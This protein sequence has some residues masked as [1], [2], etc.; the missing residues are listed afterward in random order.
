MALPRR[1]VPLRK[2]TRF[3]R[4]LVALA[5]LLMTALATGSYL[6]VAS[7]GNGLNLLELISVPFFAVL[8]GWISFSFWLA[9]L[10]FLFAF[11]EH[12]QYHVRKRDLKPVDPAAA[13]KRT[14]VLMP[15]YNES[16]RRVF[17]GVK[18]M[19]SELRHREGADRF[20]FYILSDTTDPEVWLEEEAAWSELVESLGAGDSLFYRHRAKNLARKAG[21]I[22]DFVER[23]GSR[24]DYMIVLDADSLLAASTMQAM[25]QRMDENDQLGILQIPP[26]PIGRVSFF[27]RL[28]QFAA[29]VYGPSFVKGF[30][31][32]AGDEGNYW[33]HNAI[34]RVEAFRRHCDLPVLPGEP[35]LGGE[36]LSHDFVEAALMVRA[37]WKVQ[38]ATDL[39][40][41]YEECPTTL[42]DYAQ[43]DQRW[44]QGNLQHAKLLVNEEFRTLSQLHFSCGVMSYLASPLWV[45]FTI[46][47]IAGTI[48]DMRGETATNP[49]DNLPG[50]IIIF[51][52]AMLLL[53]LPKLWGV[54]LVSQ[55]RMR[56]A[57]H[58]GYLALWASA[59]LETVC[60]VLLSPIMAVFHT[61]YVIAVLT[62][63]NVRWSAQQR[64]ERSVSWGEATRQFSGLTI[65]GLLVTALLAIFVPSLLAWFSPLLVGVVLS[66]P[67]AVVLGS[68]RIGL[69]LRRRGL[70]LIP[71]ES[72]PPTICVYHRWA[73][74]QAERASGKSQPATSWFEAVIADP[75]AFLRHAR[76]QSSTA[77]NMPLSDSEREAI[78]AAFASGGAGAIPVELRSKLLLDDKALT[79]LHLE[80][81]LA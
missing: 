43:R 65:G 60:S 34:I 37:G 62:G 9:T 58:G 1:V 40:G 56:V 33:G 52:A 12:W 11:R 25:V 10:G 80:S 6:A 38:V 53:L 5:T 76:V 54:L 66:I 28:Q 67:I 72:A 2:T 74:E 22:A 73:L 23:W 61:R 20:D 48:I 46:L 57:R 45:V 21:N 31:I 36:I 4:V 24:H 27:A 26:V 44:C 42:S 18:A 30:S 68:Q 7:A 32:W 15:V 69:A 63:T 47:C 70:L 49:P 41:S 59:L 81:Q 14:A 51:T 64:D 16:P 29:S 19:I 35:P 75:K 17:A 13:K 78:A 3:I 71:A 79:S 77:S 39:G 50:A 8:F 55:R